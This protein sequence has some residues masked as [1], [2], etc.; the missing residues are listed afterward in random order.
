MRSQRRVATVLA[1]VASFVVVTAGVAFA[2][3]KIDHRGMHFVAADPSAR[4]VLRSDPDRLEEDL[5]GSFESDS[6]RYRWGRL[7]VPFQ[8][9]TEPINPG[10]WTAHVTVTVVNRPDGDDGPERD[11]G[12][13]STVFTETLDIPITGR[14]HTYANVRMDQD[15]WEAGANDCIFTWSVTPGAWVI[16]DDD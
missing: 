16:N 3:S 13:G 12:D 2:W 11:G 8:A 4:V 15:D 5:S 10:G 7:L 6:C 9:Q 14:M 1:V